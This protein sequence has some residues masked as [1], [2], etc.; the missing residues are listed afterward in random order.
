[1][2]IHA[3]AALGQLPK[4]VIF[5]LDNTLYPYE[6]AHAAGM[7]ALIA[8]AQDRLGPSGGRF[9][10]AFTEAR[11]VLKQDLGPCAAAHDRLLYMHRTLEVL[12]LK[13]Q[14]L[15]ALDFEQTY[16]RAFLNASTLRPG[17]RSLLDTLRSLGIDRVLVTDL[18]TRIQ[19]RKLVYHGIDE[20]FEYI[21]TSEEAGGDKPSDII[22]YQLRKKIGNIEPPIWSIGDDVDKDLAGP[23]AYFG[24]VGIHVTEDGA[25][26]GCAAT[27]C[28]FEGLEKHLRALALQG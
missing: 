2:K 10:A 17:A 4:L 11:G 12:G 21:L 3:P 24:A 28:S 20:A 26:P 7:A 5:D 16:W 23:A 27:C 15:L 13:S 22:W 18:T 8:K 19:F 25:Q 6:P 14:P 1:M 9:L